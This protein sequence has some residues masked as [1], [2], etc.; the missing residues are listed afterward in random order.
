[1]IAAMSRSRPTAARRRQAVQRVTLEG[2]L[3]VQ[4][5]TYGGI[6]ARLEAPDRAAACGQRRARV[7]RLEDYLTRSPNF[8]AAAG[9]YAGRI[10]GGRFELDG[11]EHQLPKNDGNNTLH[12][13][14]AGFA[15]RV[16]SIE[17]A[18]RECVTLSYVSADGEAGFPG[19]LRTV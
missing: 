7:R 8:G 6:I 14:P 13:G 9:R 17:A 2:G 15:K 19:T 12:G 5:L 4:V 16:W 18:T 10:E 1:M 11:V 3:V